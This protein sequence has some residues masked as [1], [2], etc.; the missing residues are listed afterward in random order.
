MRNSNDRWLVLRE[1]ILSLLDSSMS[2]IDEDTRNLVR[3][4][5]ESREYGVALEWLNSYFIAND[6]NISSEDEKMMAFL[7][8]RM[9]L[10]LSTER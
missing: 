7:S 2:Q 6:V 3:E 10:N 5:V 8:E 4:F 1:G 9:G